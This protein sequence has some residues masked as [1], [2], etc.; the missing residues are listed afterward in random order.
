MLSLVSLA[1]RGRRERPCTW[2]FRPFGREAVWGALRRTPTSVKM[3]AGAVCRGC[4]RDSGPE[5][6]E[7]SAPSRLPV[8]GPRTACWESACSG[9]GAHPSVSLAEIRRFLLLLKATGSPSVGSKD[10][11]REGPCWR[12]TWK[13][14]NR[15]FSVRYY[16]LQ[17]SL[18]F[19]SI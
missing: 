9:A 10:A 13:A 7:N 14:D 5:P 11:G 6:R 3:A 2:N 18:A 8:K 16:L 12:P 15:P 4:S 1:R 19:K 17:C